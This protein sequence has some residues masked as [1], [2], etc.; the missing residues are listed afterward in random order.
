MGLFFNAR[1][2][3]SYQHMLNRFYNILWL[4]LM[5]VC[6]VS[7]VVKLRMLFRCIFIIFNP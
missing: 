1:N 7:T 6:C 4:S 3:I 5:S 2:L